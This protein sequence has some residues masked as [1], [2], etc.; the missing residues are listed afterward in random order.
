MEN[1]YK[2]KLGICGIDAKQNHERNIVKN[3]FMNTI[4]RE[5]FKEIDLPV[6]DYS[7]KYILNN[8]YFKA[9]NHFKSIAPNGEVLS[10]SDDLI[11][12]LVSFSRTEIETKGRICAFGEERSFLAADGEKIN[13]Y[14]YGGL[15]YG[16]SGAEDEADAIVAGINFAE[17]IGVKNFKIKL[18]NTDI[19]MG[20]LNSYANKKENLE[21]LK[22]II[23]GKLDNDVDYAVL[24]TLT[25]LKNVEGGSEIIKELS[26]KLENQQSI[27]GLLNVFEI[28]NVLAAYD[29][30]SYVTVMPAYLGQKRYDN[31]MVF[32]IE[33][34]KGREVIYGGRCDCIKGTDNVKGVYLAVNS[35]EAT[36]IASEN[37]IIKNESENKTVTVLTAGT[38]AAL[39]K[40]YRV[41]K[42]FY[43]ENL[44][45]KMVYNV[46]EKEA[47]GY[48]GKEEK[49]IIIYIDAEGNITH[50]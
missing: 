40:A 48:M 35:E 33:D 45:T 25:P 36:E 1:N 21:R 42:D 31:G 22:K 19:F 7:E 15:I 4:G 17:E 5:G 49:E 28:M 26:A 3:I 9:Q 46:E 32:S 12:G 11:A 14:C 39:S 20:V 44:K 38:K 34:E 6:L 2:W 50:S 10:L 30:D 29:L 47:L 13:K 18:G 23:A 43:K 24:Q 27:D 8:E 41:R 16:E 37:G